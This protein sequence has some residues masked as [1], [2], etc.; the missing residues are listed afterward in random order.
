MNI[1][2]R[3]GF[4]SSC[5]MYACKAPRPGQWVRGIPQGSDVPLGS[6][7]CRRSGGRR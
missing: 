3:N 7:L 5:L 1:L 6:P 4:D 2:V